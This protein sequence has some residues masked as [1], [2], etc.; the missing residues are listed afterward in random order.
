MTEL[1]AFLAAEAAGPVATPVRAFAEALAQEQGVEAVLFYG[2]ALRTGS[3]DGV[4]DFY[5][6]TDGVRRRG[7]RGV[8]ERALWPEI[9]FVHHAGPQ[10]MLHAKAAVV[11]LA[12]FARAAAGDGVDTTVWTRFAQP[13]RLLH[14]RTPAARG[15]VEAAL[16]S[17][18]ATAARFAAA[19][20]PARGEAS[21]YWAALFRATYAAELRIE[22]PGREVELLS[23]DTARWA[24][25][26]PLAWATAGV[27][28]E[29]DGSE[30]A[31]QLDVDAAVGLRRAWARRRRWGRPLNLAR[32]VKA[33]LTAPGVAV[34]AAGKLARHTDVRV[35]ITPW[36]ERHPL[37]AAIPLLWRLWRRR[38]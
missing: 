1:A 14:A 33:A 8:V 12:V 15:A 22:R 36:R 25:L 6:L 30:L 2:S 28:F 24:A 38:A 29:R 7:L 3:Q 34:Y 20:G 13:C 21:A 26:L 35:T 17:A 16:A 11:P 23:T 18:A 37:L 10:G 9:R 5:V 4:L 27:A 31:P 19:L 32:L